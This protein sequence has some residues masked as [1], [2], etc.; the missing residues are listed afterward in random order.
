MKYDKNTMAI[1]EYI[2]YEGRVFHVP[3]LLGL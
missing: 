1:T 3:S 2:T